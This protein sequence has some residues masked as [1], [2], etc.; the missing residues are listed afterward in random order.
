VPTGA[1]RVTDESSLNAPEAQAPAPRKRGGQQVIPEEEARLR[2]RQQ[3]LDAQAKEQDARE[4]R[5]QAATEQLLLSREREIQRKDAEIQRLQAQRE[6][7]NAGRTIRADEGTQARLERTD[8]QRSDA[9]LRADERNRQAPGWPANGE[10]TRIA[11]HANQIRRERGQPELD[12]PADAP[13]ATPMTGEIPAPVKRARKVAAKAAP[14]GA[15]AAAPAKRVRKAAKAAPEAAPG[16]PEAA[17]EAPAKRVRKVAQK[18]APE[19]APEAAAPEAPPVKRVRKAAAKAVPEA[20]PEVAPAAPPVKKAARA[21][22]AAAPEAAVPEGEK[23]LRGI[24]YEDALKLPPEQWQQRLRQ[25]QDDLKFMKEARKAAPEGAPE[26]PPVKK[27]ARVVKKAAPEAAPEA[28]VKKATRGAKK[29]AP[30]AAP[31]APAKKAPAKRV[32]KKAAPEA[33]KAVP[34][35][36]VYPE[37]QPKTMKELQDMSDDEIIRYADSLEGPAQNSAEVVA[38]RMAQ[39]ARIRKEEGA[40][41][42]ETI[43]E[44][45]K[46][47][48]RPSPEAK[49]RPQG[50]AKSVEQIRA[51]NEAS[52]AETR[53]LEEKAFPERKRPVAKKRGPGKSAEQIRAENEASKAETARLAKKLPAKT[54]MTQAEREAKEKLPSP[55]AKKAANKLV[56]LRAE[57]FDKN[58]PNVPGED[59]IALRRAQKQ[60]AEGRAV[61]EVKQDLNDRAEFLRRAAEIEREDPNDLTGRRAIHLDQLADTYERAADMAGK[62]GPN[63]DRLTPGDKVE[64]T[65]KDKSITKGTVAKRGR[66]TYIDW[67]DGESQRVLP[68]RPGRGIKKVG[69]AEPGV[70]APKA[71]KPATLVELRKEAGTLNVPGRS[72]MDRPQLEEALAARRKK[73]GESDEEHAARLAKLNERPTVTRAA[74]RKVAKAREAAPEAAPE[75]PAA[76]KKAAAKK[77]AKPSIEDHAANALLEAMPPEARKAILDSMTPD[78]R[79]QVEEAVQRVKGAAARPTVKRA[80][81][82]KAVT[83]LAD[84]TPDQRR[85]YTDLSPGEQNSY[86]AFLRNGRSHNDALEA[87]RESVN[88]RTTRAAEKAN[89]EAE[90]RPVKRAARKVAR[91]AE[92]PTTSPLPAHK[93]T[94]KAAEKSVAKLVPHGTDGGSIP[95]KRAPKATGVQAPTKA[96]KVARPRVRRAA[97]AKIAEAPPAPETLQSNSKAD[98]LPGGAKHIDLKPLTEG[99]DFEAGPGAKKGGGAVTVDELAVVPDHRDVISRAQQELNDGKSPASVARD[100]RGTAQSLRNVAAIR[101]GG[102]GDKE[103]TP[104]IP[105]SPEILAEKKKNW[106]NWFKRAKQFDDLAARLEATKRP[107]VARKAAVAKAVPEVS[108]PERPTVTRA[109]R[110]VAKAAPEAPAR[111]QRSPRL[112]PEQQNDIADLRPIDKA[113][114]RSLRRDRLSHDDALAQ[115]KRERQSADLGAAAR[116]EEDATAK[117]RAR[118]ALDRQRAERKIAGQKQREAID[119]ENRKDLAPILDEAGVKYDD[120]SEMQR[121]KVD[122]LKARVEKKTLSKKR[123]AE[124][125]RADGDDRMAAIARIIER[126][127]PRKVA[128]RKVAKAAPEAPA[129]AVPAKKVTKAAARPKPRLTFDEKGNPVVHLGMTEDEVN[130]LTP[131]QL[132]DVARAA[133]VE[134]PKGKDNQAKILDIVRQ[135]AK[136]RLGEAAPKAVRKA[137]PKV[138]PAKAAPEGNVQE[139]LRQKEAKRLR[140]EIKD[141]IRSRSNVKRRQLQDRLQGVENAGHAE[142]IAPE[143]MTPDGKRAWADSYRQSIRDGFGDEVAQREANIDAFKAA[144][145]ARAGA[146]ETPA[147][148][149]KKAA[150]KVAKA[151]PEAAPEAA[152]VKLTPAQFQALK[153]LDSNTPHALSRK[154]LQERLTAAGVVEYRDGRWHITPVGRDVLARENKRPTVKRAVAKA[155]PEAAPEA[156]P[157]KRAAKKVAKAAPE[158]PSTEA[159]LREQI[160]Q[161]E[162]QQMIME[163]EQSN[164]RIQNAVKHSRRGGLPVGDRGFKPYQDLREGDIERLSPSE[165]QSM[166]DDLVERRDATSSIRHKRMAVRALDRLHG[167]HWE[168]P[169]EAPAPTKATKKVAKAAPEATPEVPKAPPAPPVK[170]VIRERK[171]TPVGQESPLTSKLRGFGGDQAKIQAELDKDENGL[172]ALREVA[173]DLGLDYVQPKPDLKRSILEAVSGRKRA[174]RKVARAPK[175]SPLPAHEPAAPAKAARAAPNVPEN[176]KDRVRPG[177]MIALAH[178]QKGDRVMVGK[179]STGTWGPSRRITDTPITVD[180]QEIVPVR[181][182]RGGVDNRRVLFGHDD[183]GNEIRV[184]GDTGHS[185]TVAFRAARPEGAKVAKAAKAAPD[186]TGRR[187]AALKKALKPVHDNAHGQDSSINNYDE[188]VAEGQAP[189][190]TIRHMRNRADAYDE[191]VKGSTVNGGRGTRAYGY[192]MTNPDEVKRLQEQAVRLRKAADDFEAENKTIRPS[193]VAKAVPEA[194]PARPKVTRAAAK[195]VTAPEAPSTEA[196]SP[197]AEERLRRLGTKSDW[198]TETG[199]KRAETDELIRQGLVERRAGHTSLFKRVTPGIR[200]TP[201]GRQHLKSLE[202]PEAPAPANVAPAVKRVV[203]KAVPEAAPETPAPRAPRK[204]AAPRP[205]ASAE[206][207]REKVGQNRADLEGRLSADQKKEL[208]GLSPRQR[209]RYWVRRV[210]SGDDHNSALSK[211][212]GGAAP[213]AA[214]PVVKRATAPR[215]VAT[216]AAAPEAPAKRMTREQLMQEINRR[217]DAGE[218]LHGYDQT[219]TRDEL[220]RVLKGESVE[221]RGSQRR[222]AAK[223][224]AVERAAEVA[225]APV[226]PR[227]RP[228]SGREIIDQLQAAKTDEEAARIVRPIRSRQRLDDALRTVGSPP[229]TEKEGLAGGKARLLESMRPGVS[230]PERPVVKRAVK[231]VVPEGAPE[232][233]AARKV[234]KAAATSGGYR[235]VTQ[236]GLPRRKSNDLKAKEWG[237]FKGYKLEADG[238]LSK[239]GKKSRLKGWDGLYQYHGKEIEDW[240]KNNVIDDRETIG[241]SEGLRPAEAQEWARGDESLTNLR[242]RLR[243]RQASKTARVAKKATPEAAP[244]RP[245]VKRAAPRKVAAKAA[246]EAV[247]QAEA[248]AR[249]KGEVFDKARSDA[250]IVATLDQAIANEGSDRSILHSIDNAT[251]AIPMAG[252]RGISTKDRDALKRAFDTKGREGLKRALANYERRHGLTRIG[253]TGEVVPFDPE[254]HR[255]SGNLHAKPGEPVLVLSPGHEIHAPGD[256]KPGVANYAR[257]MPASKTRKAAKAVTPEAPAKA[258]R[259]RVTR[260]KKAVPGTSPLQA[261]E[262]TPEVTDITEV[263]HPPKA[264]RKVAKRIPAAIKAEP[265]PEGADPDA[266]YR[267][268]AKGSSVK[269]ATGWARGIAKTREN[270]AQQREAER[271]AKAAKIVKKTPPRVYGEEP[272]FYP[273]KVAES[274]K[275]AEAPKK[276]ERPTVRRVAKK[277]AAALARPFTKRQTTEK[278]QQPEAHKPV[279]PKLFRDTLTPAQLRDWESLGSREERAQYQRLTKQGMSHEAAMEAAPRIVREAHAR[280][281]EQEKARRRPRK[282]AQKAVPEAG[283][284]E[285]PKVTRAG[286]K[287]ESADDVIANRGTIVRPSEHPGWD[288]VQHDGNKRWYILDP[289]GKLHKDGRISSSSSLEN[290]QKRLARVAGPPKAAPAKRVARKA[291]PE[292]PS[293]PEE[294]G[295]SIAQLAKEAGFKGDAAGIVPSRQLDLDQGMSRPDVAKK[296]RRDATNLEKSPLDQGST[297]PSINRAAREERADFVRRLRDLADRVED[298]KAAPERPAV[299]R[300]AK[301]AVPEAPAKATRAPRKV[302][303]KATPEAV[304][305]ERPVVKRAAPRKVAA[306]ESK[307]LKP[308][309]NGTRRKS[310]TNVQEGDVVRGASGARGGSEVPRRV[311]KVERDGNS[312][313]IT[314]DDGSTLKGNSNTAVWLGEAPKAEAPAAKRAVKKAAPSTPEAPAKTARPRVTRAAAKKTAPEVPARSPEERNQRFELAERR[315]LRPSEAND[316]A[317]SEHKTLASWRKAHPESE[318][319]AKATRPRVTRAS[320][321]K[322]APEAAAPEAPAKAARPTSKQ[323]LSKPEVQRARGSLLHQGDRD[324]SDDAVAKEMDR[325]KRQDNADIRRLRA[326]RR[327]PLD[328]NVPLRG[329]P[330]GDGGVMHGDSPSMQLAQKL[331]RRGDRNG[332]ANKIMELRHSYSGRERQNDPDATQKAVQEL[333]L[334]RLEEQD[335]EVRKLYDDA[336]SE[337]DAEPK[338]LPD[339]PEGTPQSARQL[340]SDLNRIP[341]ARRAEFEDNKGERI[342]AVDELAQVYRDIDSGKL[343]GS[344]DID[345]R[346]T[347][348]VRRYHE[349]R[350]GAYQMWD[351]SPT[352]SDKQ[353]T[354]N[355]DLRQWARDREAA[356]PHPSPTPGSGAPKVSEPRT[357]IPDPNEPRVVKAQK[358]LQA[359]EALHRR[360][361]ADGSG[362]LAD[363]LNQVIEARQGNDDPAAFRRAV[364]QRLLSTPGEK[365]DPKTQGYDDLRKA[366]AGESFTNPEELGTRLRQELAKRGI[367]MTSTPG[368]QTRF[369]PDLHRSVGGDIPDNADVQVIRPGLIFTDK[370]GTVVTLQKPVVKRVTVAPVGSIHTR[371]SKGKFRDDR[372]AITKTLDRA[373]DKIFGPPTRPTVKRAGAKVTPSGASHRSTQRPLTGKPVFL[374]ADLFDRDTDPRGVPVRNYTPVLGGGYTIKNGTAWRRNGVTYVIEHDETGEGKRRAIEAAKVLEHH[375]STLPAGARKYQKSYV[376]NSGSNPEDPEFAKKHGVDKFTSAMTAGGGETHIW[377]PGIKMTPEGRVDAKQ[378]LSDLNHEYGH[379]ADVDGISETKEWHEAGRNADPSRYI[380]PKT[381]VPLRSGRAKKMVLKPQPGARYPYGITPYGGSS[382]V[383]DFAESVDL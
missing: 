180:R 173:Q 265:V 91:A 119:A 32:A 311:T 258:A 321:K 204:V 77:T 101:Y 218:D 94:P 124:M 121:A 368:A 190:T 59:G 324:L 9:V 231:K 210:E 53:R 145:A 120:L 292:A 74:P 230:A 296:I 10:D 96:A 380:D 225:A 255:V 264:P 375:H 344:G 68:S 181:N 260:A 246:P 301:K 233:P 45:V 367:T 202:A 310:M 114:Y 109:A 304:A 51:E 253:N 55:T 270:L 267:A 117:L 252:T 34:E 88:A 21:A 57:A 154:D 178:I 341:L 1:G 268:R 164:I 76:T 98:Y 376:W 133:G 319:P 47:Q 92:R 220:E 197:G 300:A 112:T 29:A 188:R 266:Y 335:P 87:A 309:T 42:G 163:R 150:R 201:K 182:R 38:K 237:A 290:A 165:I 302:A 70:E 269:V 61:S 172:D 355:R 116:Q 56:K 333:R 313:T 11:E 137:A 177:G 102:W 221:L 206:A 285:R 161:R 351:L 298:K 318:A 79:A 245:V 219:F 143:E 122:V 326:L 275:T 348:I 203:K 228:A 278:V 130:G 43:A 287:V 25:I 207:L 7:D 232:A 349:S 36:K 240:H 322:A 174:P 308:L 226:T 227:K 209:A 185:G 315:G 49:P 8:R 100:L 118:E 373:V 352:G 217:R 2:D 73:E 215:K 78:E 294:A 105:R 307:E 75:A 127:A 248:A 148:P 337:M 155:A 4:K 303:A 346:V 176:M 179:N 167:G 356:G 99:L 247:P 238:S 377:Q 152:P 250:H 13:P 241:L 382:D 54:P 361:T 323:D 142:D 135:M 20:A 50:P 134:P 353:R 358:R 257:V 166:T 5:L 107:R 52:K 261:H 151:A 200:V 312:I 236:T 354:I 141:A 381:W 67:E 263:P 72:R 359:R 83:K 305:P 357:D 223:A 86:R 243:E 306:P 350:D 331:A 362:E 345:N 62:R 60:L 320:A 279:A 18:A 69:G 208:D 15:P 90:G 194:A 156:P 93:Q 26:A 254:R 160:Q 214:R 147:A 364:R 81:A 297:D 282:V 46:R 27:A 316:F 274:P 157:A 80:V 136:K 262:A 286:T 138:V 37:R 347:R 371:T 259:P 199:I 65:N 113:R 244:E 365:T 189:A 329:D 372:S 213:A 383:E 330:Q 110:K 139:Q 299:K 168:P 276:A 272:A 332:S 159:R 144:Q 205:R 89:A 14:E 71:A 33:V 191:A 103:V 340:L 370:D 295:P 39:A 24:S 3:R 123:A 16:A 343:Q 104:G 273:R 31:E 63:P 12:I 85:Q 97:P 242:K 327:T 251:K 280:G 131:A 58:V 19:A 146:P 216:K 291:A 153:R 35:K 229:S 30:E 235:A 169:G 256:E 198:I 158:G 84:L 281:L 66:L 249:S 129:K 338:P 187:A 360:S 175:T 378:L 289:E 184:G 328:Q 288:I 111:L 170:R 234:A 222:K 271:E 48:A 195:K 196:L 132:D 334:M 379:N 284:P 283:A 125:L 325:I 64:R 17:P 82:K 28:P 23:D 186:V 149:A 128:A 40:P 374:T 126:P 366:L 106:T 293:K 211:A 41:P 363:M 277:V 212:T 162:A 224:R 115:T 192:D 183:Q 369:N 95:N 108:A 6:A 342:S 339:L 317:D 171:P 22:K 44:R 314:R 239:D 140:A 193:K 336:I